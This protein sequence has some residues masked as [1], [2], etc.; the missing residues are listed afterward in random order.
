MNMVVHAKRFKKNKFNHLCQQ[1][2]NIFSVKRPERTPGLSVLKP[3][4]FQDG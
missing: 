3:E 2:A 1:S 4:Q